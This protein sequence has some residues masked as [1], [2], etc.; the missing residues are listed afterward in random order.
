MQSESRTSYD[1][2]ERV[3]FFGHDDWTTRDHRRQPVI[4]WRVRR[5]GQH[6]RLL[7]RGLFANRPDS[8]EAS[9]PKHEPDH[10]V[11]GTPDAAKTGV[12]NGQTKKGPR[13]RNKWRRRRAKK[14]QISF[15]WKIHEIPSDQI[16]LCV[17]ILP[18]PRPNCC[19]AKTY[20][21]RKNKNY[22]PASYC[23]QSPLQER[24]TSA[25]LF[26]FYPPPV[27]VTSPPMTTQLR[28]VFGEV[29]YSYNIK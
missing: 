1:R 4:E 12:E 18:G 5:D 14:G 6:R 11:H 23:R 19:S 17:V 16:G 28:L 13:M 26:S 25:L 27:T 7:P 22:R 21:R 2:N 20:T 24:N 8:V 15:P 10:S 9:R 29:V 3:L